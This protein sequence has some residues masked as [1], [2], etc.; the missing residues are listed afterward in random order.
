MTQAFAAWSKNPLLLR[1]STSGG[2]FSELAAQTI[3]HGGMVAGAAY[4]G[5]LVVEHRVAHSESELSSL[6]GVKYV[7]GGIS[8]NVYSE[9]ESALNEGREVLFSGLPCQCAAVRKKFG[10]SPHLL[11]VDLVCF[12]AP[13][14]KL[15][16]K[17]VA[18]LENKQGKRLSRINPR[19]K[20]YGWGRKTYYGY[21]W[22]DGGTTRK[23]SIF[24][25]YAQLFYSGL[26]FRECC[27]KCP[28][29]GVERESDITL[30]DLWGAEELCEG[31]DRRILRSG[32]SCVVHTQKGLDIFRRLDVGKKELGVDAVLVHNSPIVQSPTK[33][34]QW[35]RFSTDA[36]NMDFEALA[37]KYRLKVSVAAFVKYRILA[38][39]AR[40]LKWLS[41]GV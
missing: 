25:P 30:G 23:L 14:Q 36:E 7:H 22:A 24:D 40:A 31:I 27:F 6:R 12:G 3:G 1:E 15:W 8:R 35:K 28:F 39:A 16:L 5:N 2:L 38:M 26:G 33:P 18:W 9:V 10:F 11:I 19:D 32:M 29:R 17:Y 37:T 4:G 20:R 41:K 34:P 13:P 21:K